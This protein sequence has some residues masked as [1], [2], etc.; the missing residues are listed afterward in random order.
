MAIDAHIFGRILTT[1]LKSLS[2]DGV[3]FPPQN[4]AIYS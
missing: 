1:S 2:T 4:T 3:N